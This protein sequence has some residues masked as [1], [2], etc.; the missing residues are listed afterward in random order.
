[1]QHGQGK[2]QNKRR[3]DP[4]RTRR[5]LLK[6][7][8]KCFS[9]SGYAGTTVDSVVAAAGVNK[10]LVYHYFGSKQKLYAA[11]LREVYGSLEQV[12]FSAIN[13]AERPEQA[14]CELLDAYFR[15]LREHPEFVRL[16]LWENLNDGR[17]LRES[18]RILNKDPFLSRMRGIV[19]AGRKTGTFAQDIAPR[20]LLTAMIG[21]CFIYHSN[22]YTLSQALGL[23]LADDAELDRGLANA[24]RLLCQG[25]GGGN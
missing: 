13:E 9:R 21:M 20:H 6:V 15:F 2:K 4:A 17:V 25:I 3:R 18:G 10:R 11:V 1:M 22:R 14:L 12:E 8:I 23:D 5:H 24:R 7:A 16:L 19:A